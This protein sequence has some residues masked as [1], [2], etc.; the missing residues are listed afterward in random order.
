[1]GLFTS[2]D[3]VKQETKL[4]AK[5]EKHDDRS[6]KQALKDLAATEKAETKAAKV[7]SDIIDSSPSSQSFIPSWDPDLNPNP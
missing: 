2:D 7:R 1:M 5:E 6:V 3:P 4:L